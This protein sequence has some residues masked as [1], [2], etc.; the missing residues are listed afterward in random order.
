M[1]KTKLT[2]LLSSAVIFA[3][4][5]VTGA[6]Q[7]STWQ[8]DNQ[9][10]EL[11][12]ASV[13]NKTIAEI[14][15]FTQLNGQI[16]NGQLRVEIALSS[17]DT[18]IPIRNERMQ[19]HLFN[20]AEFP[21]IQATGQLPM[22]EVQGLNVGQTLALNIPLNLTIRD[23]TKP[24]S[25]EVMVTRLTENQVSATTTAPIMVRANDFDLVDGIEK[26]RNIAGL[27]EID[28]VVPVTFSVS[29]SQAN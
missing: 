12:F 24:V 23:R 13:K 1:E 10:A 22:A 15:R 7:A 28:Y 20:A 17:L 11:R 25:A 2:A 27:S 21:M 3:S 8:L 6:A 5:A 4:L 9:Q 18:Q 14:H 29:F 16:S 19:Q 26:L